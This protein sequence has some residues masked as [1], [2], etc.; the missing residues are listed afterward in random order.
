[1]RAVPVPLGPFERLLALNVD[2]EARKDALA[3]AGAGDVAQLLA[4]GRRIDEEF[5][6]RLR[7]LPLL[8]LRIRYEEIEPVRAE[9]LR[10]L[11]EVSARLLAEPWPGLR[12]AARRHYAPNEFEAILRRHLRLYAQEVDGLGRSARLSMLLVPLRLRLASLMQE[13]AAALAREACALL[14]DRAMR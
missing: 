5:L 8:S 7:S 2:K 1:M 13:Q 4:E 14:Y 11:L 10:Q 12:R 9:R 3:I 6:A